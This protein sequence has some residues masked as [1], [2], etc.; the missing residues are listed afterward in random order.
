MSPL[1]LL[2]AV[3]LLVPL[4]AAAQDEA[5]GPRI[6]RG[7]PES[8]QRPPEQIVLGLSQDEVAITATFDGSDLLIFG[9]IRRVAEMDL[10]DLG[11]IVTV[12]GPSVPATVF[13]KERRLGI[14]INSNA[15][16]VSQAP[17]FYAV[18]GTA[19]LDDILS[20]TENLRQSVT[21]PRAIRAIGNS[22]E[23]SGD[24]IAALIRLR[25]DDDLYQL[26][27]E[28]VDLAEGTLFS[29]RIALPA[30]IV[31]GNYTVR[32]LLTRSGTVVDT[33]ST[34]IGVQ[35]VGLERWLFNFAHE[36]AFFYGLTSL[37]LAIAAGWAASA[38]FGRLRR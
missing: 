19:P 13:R 4:S 38:L 33:Y 14:W 28:G 8:A 34:T 32:I 27:D 12:A 22:V 15:V 25:Q 18:A 23:N 21:I 35:K 5:A 1:A 9:A 20:A 3:L 37:I 7:A 24:Y 10:D 30:N 26:L 16:N 17:S 6:P 29:T 31:E 11:V 2:L 36:Q